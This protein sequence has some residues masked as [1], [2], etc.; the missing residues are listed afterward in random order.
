MPARKNKGKSKVGNTF[1]SNK[2]PREEELSQADYPRMHDVLRE[3][4]QIPSE[5]LSSG[6]WRTSYG[7]SLCALLLT[8]LTS[9]PIAA[10]ML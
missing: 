9:A 4:M 1:A 3:P 2:R 7:G 10:C 5:Q 6:A 8:T